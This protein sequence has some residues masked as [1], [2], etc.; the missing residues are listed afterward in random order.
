MGRQTWWTAKKVD[1]MLLE[2]HGQG[3]GC[4]YKPWLD[5]R[6][7]ASVGMT[8]RVLGVTVPRLYTLFSK[9]EHRTFLLLDH[10]SRTRDI[11]ENFPL[12]LELTRRLARELGIRHP[13]YPGSTDDMV[14]TVDFLVDMLAGA[15]QVPPYAVSVKPA[16]KLEDLRV[17]EKQQLERAASQALGF[18]HLIIPPSLLETQRATNLDWMY[19]GAS[20]DGMP[21]EYRTTFLEHVARFA[22]EFPYGTE[23][24]LARFCEAFEAR[25]SLEPGTGLDVAKFLLRS[26]RLVTDLERGG[27]PQRGLCDF[28]LA[29]ATEQLYAARG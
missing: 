17:V 19:S 10:N 4:A 12:P 23:S 25:H 27:I 7:F 20:N 6:S 24:T 21:D 26:R 11:R 29:L 15:S 1:Q 28:G 16:S 18:T 14:M 8:F 3:T 2:G 9:Q 5:A 22:R 13:R